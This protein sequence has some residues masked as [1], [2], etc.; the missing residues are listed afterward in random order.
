MVEDHANNS[1]W[2][3]ANPV[4]GCSEIKALKALCA[5]APAHHSTAADRQP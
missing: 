2:Q 1:Y 5:A 4:S 3:I